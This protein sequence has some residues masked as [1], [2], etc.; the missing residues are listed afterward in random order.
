MSLAMMSSPLPAGEPVALTYPALV[1][2]TDGPVIRAPPVP[3]RPLHRLGPE[4]HAG[5][6]QQGFTGDVQRRRRGEENCRS[7]DVLG[8]GSD[9]HRH[10]GS[11]VLT[12]GDHLVVR[13]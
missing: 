8:F 1:R 12:Q 5:I 9:V 3:S 4:M 10:R 2:I 7:G 6:D 11:D 13:D